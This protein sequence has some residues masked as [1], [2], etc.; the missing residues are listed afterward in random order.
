ML[1]RCGSVAGGDLLRRCGICAKIKLGVEIVDLAAFIA[2]M[3]VVVLPRTGFTALGDRLRDVRVKA[4]IG[5][6]IEQIVLADASSTRPT[7]HSSTGCSISSLC[8]GC[9]GP[10]IVSIA[11][12]IS[13]LGST[14]SVQ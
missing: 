3:S 5:S 12:D 14:R 1:E 10:Q 8:R 6:L 13:S 2:A 11:H 7:L 9:H 4:Q